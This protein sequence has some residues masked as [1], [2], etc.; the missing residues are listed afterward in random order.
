MGSVSYITRKP[1]RPHRVTPRPYSAGHTLDLMA[2]CIADEQLA[3]GL[4]VVQAA[5]SQS[6][7]TKHAARSLLRH[8][9]LQSV[10]NWVQSLVDPQLRDLGKALESEVRKHDPTQDP[11][12]LEPLLDSID[13]RVKNTYGQIHDEI[14]GRLKGVAVAVAGKV[15]A[16]LREHHGREAKDAKPANMT[17]VPIHGATLEEHFEK[18]ANDVAFKYGAAVR[19][20]LKAG[21]TLEELLGRF[22]NVSQ[23]KGSEPVVRAAQ[24]L[25]LLEAAMESVNKVIEAAVNTYANEVVQQI[26]DAVEPGEEQPELGYEW[27]AVLD[28]ATCEQCEFYSGNRWTNEFK[29]VADAPE[30]PDD[31]PLH[32]GCRC[33][34]VMVDLGEPKAPEKDFDN[35]LA[36]YSRSEQV[37]AFGESNLRAYHRGDITANELVGQRNNLMTLDEFKKAD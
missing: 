23:V 2:R 35:W 34:L 18:Q 26:G 5:D 1:Q 28:Q 25:S 3:R 10:A 14:A 22:K 27:V 13:K 21:D 36:G 32:F 7:N 24:S 37:A 19:Q 33:S 4:M 29:P 6:P 11:E 30:F 20:G 15:K 31:P 8:A 16:G 9:Q 12:E 17:Q